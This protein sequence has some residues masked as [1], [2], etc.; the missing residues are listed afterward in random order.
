MKKS[1]LAIVVLFASL[2]FCLGCGSSGG[3]GSGLPGNEVTP[4]ATVIG[5]ITGNGAKD[6]VDV[7]LVHT[8]AV[9]PPSAKTLPKAD[10]TSSANGMLYTTTDSK[11]S[12]AFYRVPIG[13]YNL[14]AKKNG[15]QSGFQPEI[16][17]LANESAP[18][19][20][21]V[22][23][24]PTGEISGTVQVPSDFSGKAGIVVFI[25]GSSFAGYTDSNGNY[26][27]SEVPVGN[28]S[29]SFLT[30]GLKQSVV[31]GVSVGAGALTSLPLVTLSRD[32]SF[33]SG[34]LW[35]GVFPTPPV[36]PGNNWAYYNLTEKK[37]Y[38]YFDGQWLLMVQDGIAGLTGQQGTTGSQGLNGANGA[39]G[40]VGN[41]GPSGISIS[42]QG[43]LA[44]PPASPQINWAYY[45]LTDKK[46]YIWV[47]TIWATMLQD[48]LIGSAGPI[49]PRGPVGPTGATGLTGMTGATGTTGAAGALGVAGNAGPV[50]ISISWQGS[51]ALPPVLP[52]LNWAYYN[53]S[54]RT[55][56]FWNGTGWV[57]LTSDGIQ[58]NVGSLGATGS[59]GA[60][61]A[62]GATGLNGSNGLAGLPGSTGPTGLT[63]ATGSSGLSIFWVGSMALAPMTP[64]IN[65]A[66][67][68]PNDQKSYIW[69]GNNWAILAYNGTQGITGT[70]GTSGSTGPTGLTG[71]TGD[72]GSFGLPG[73]VGSA[74]ISGPTGNTGAS[75]PTG[76]TGAP[77][78]IGATGITGNVG[79]IGATGSTGNTGTKGVNGSIGATGGSGPAGAT[80]SVGATGA[81]GG[82][83][84][85]GA[86][87]ATG[88]TGATGA[89]GPTGTT[90][91]WKGSGSVAPS[92]P[93]IY[94][95]YYNSSDFTSYFWDGT[96][97][98]VLA[99]SG[100]AAQGPTGSTG[101][102]GPSGSPGA[103]G[104]TGLSIF[105]QGSSSF[106]PSN[107][108]IYFAYYNTLDSTSYYF[109]GNVWKTLA[110]DGASAL[111]DVSVPVVSNATSSYSSG[112]SI[113]LIWDANEKVI[114]SIEYGL[115][116]DYGS[117]TPWTTQ[118]GQYGQS[119][120]VP[121][122][123]GG[124]IYHFRIRVKNS[125]G[126]VGISADIT[127]S[128]DTLNSISLATNSFSV[129]FGSTFDLSEI[130]MHVEY[131]KAGGS[132][133]PASGTWTIISGGGT[134]SGNVFSAPNSFGTTVLRFS[135]SD[136]LTKTADL[137][138][139][140]ADSAPF[141]TACGDGVN[142]KLLKI[143][144][145]SFTMGS[146]GGFPANETPAH[147]VV[148]T[149][150]FYLGETE[151]TQAQYRKVMGF[152]PPS[153]FSY[154]GVNFP[155]NWV[156]WRDAAD[157]CNQLSQKAGLG[158]FYSF[159]G[160]KFSI[161]LSNP[162]FRLPT[163]AEWEYAY[164]AGTITSYFW[165]DSPDNIDSYAWY[166]D[167]SSSQTH[168]V[169]GKLPNPWG[170]YDM[171]GNVAEWCFDEFTTY[172]ATT[173]TDPAGPPQGTIQ[174]H[175]FRG[176]GDLDSSSMLRSANRN[177][178]TGEPLSYKEES[179][180]IRVC[181][182]TGPV[183]K[184]L[185]GIL[186]TPSTG[187]VNSGSNY[188][189]TSVA[190]TKSYNDFTTASLAAA[191]V[192]W[193]GTGVSGSIFNSASGTYVIKCSYTENGVTR[194]ADF[195]INSRTLTGIS[196]NPTSDSVYVDSKYDL[197][198][199]IIVTASY[200]DPN[201]TP[202]VTEVTWSGDSDIHGTNF[203]SSVPGLHTLTCSYTERGVTKTANLS[204]TV[205]PS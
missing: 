17:V 171:A 160:D 145:G 89:V 181:R 42:W 40:A 13:N 66:Y 102:I 6:G 203:Q 141:F 101:A 180:G 120:I 75:G 86:T 122:L 190:V 67:Y 172:P 82:I 12:F 2:T 131:L 54:D 92:D 104:A 117:F 98:Q 43:S 26:L 113:Q 51:L 20:L 188:D 125:P 34:I 28:Y 59:T 50:G 41:T 5:E 174:F 189:L 90:L 19:V 35:K 185:A 48:G 60:A 167:N 196:I 11:G 191:S 163:E 68:N 56:Y 72:T 127:D 121:G 157:F 176:G 144:Q 79:S 142:M 73:T 139:D 129:A 30:A 156:T 84:T 109:D 78:G 155:V 202:T 184:T 96:T 119:L 116:T 123:Q 91:V 95:A 198:T 93:Q 36:N 130:L 143:P 168:E 126:K 3:A 194:T 74:G 161:N 64:Q 27:I 14:I 187:T 134:V 118:F 62:I 132:D 178:T 147:T 149:N 88:N 49:G 1:I 9:I 186:L 166:Y 112:S 111:V 199:N 146:P 201:Y 182:F 47:G 65:W 192:V 106:A 7:F 24:K 71:P 162:S 177:S 115:T 38:I 70:T 179:P 165:G 159:A 15:N 18:L 205:D 133:S 107:P 153:P 4:T 124:R 158:K 29:V 154:Q 61:G 148:L 10:L 83:G 169:K 128:T 114:S 105:W 22:E 85:T 140:M 52:Q 23:L 170:L 110:K 197:A 32:D 138:L 44:V 103:T 136:G 135:F 16:K 58:G 137:S 80:G 200:D 77:G 183:A 81:T 97:W 63:G 164:R 57:I 173:D 8:D 37:A 94:W 100:S 33:F 53:T 39:T 99:K 151:V 55:S 175:N 150:D 204:L 87:G 108:Q 193:S 152:D 31:D 69:D 195:T 76:A 25:R 45:N 46:A 21:N